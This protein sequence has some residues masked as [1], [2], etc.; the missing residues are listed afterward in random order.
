FMFFDQ[1]T[2]TTNFQ[3]RVTFLVT[4][5]ITNGFIYLILDETVS[6]GKINEF[7]MPHP[8]GNR[9]RRENIQV[10]YASI[11]LKSPTTDRYTSFICPIT[12]GIPF[13]GK[14]NEFYMPHPGGNPLRR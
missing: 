14:I 2:L 4:L 3:N 9:H 1:S 12:E 11:Q 5:F 8:G 13:E 10:L 6:E 7:Y